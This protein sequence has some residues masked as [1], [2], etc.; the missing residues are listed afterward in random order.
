[1]ATL[2]CHL[3]GSPVKV[4]PRAAQVTCH[5]CVI[6]TMWGAAP[7]S[8]KKRIGYPKGWRF[9]K[10]FVHADGT[11]YQKGIEQ[12]GLKGSLEPTQIIVKPKK[13]AK[14]KAEEKAEVAAKIGKLKKQLK[15]E[16]RKTQQKKIETQIKKL[17]VKL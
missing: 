1:M 10:E 5:M 3:C 17:Q 9:M 6:E 8:E 14:Q 4:D 2:D 12:P 11:V 13:T 7:K 15:A 16:S